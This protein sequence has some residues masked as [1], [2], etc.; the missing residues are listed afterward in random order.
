MHQALCHVDV[1][2]QI[3]LTYYKEGWEMMTSAFETNYMRGLHPLA[4]VCK[5]W[6][7]VA[8]HHF[9]AK[10]MS[11]EV[12]QPPDHGR[13]GEYFKSAFEQDACTTMGPFG[14]VCT[15]STRSIYHSNA[16]LIPR[17]GNKT[18]TFYLY[19]GNNVTAMDIVHCLNCIAFAEYEWPLVTALHIVTDTIFTIPPVLPPLTVLSICP[20]HFT[21]HFLLAKLSAE[22]LQKL[23][24]HHIQPRHFFKTIGISGPQSPAVFPELRSLGLY[25]SVPRISQDA[26]SNWYNSHEHNL[27]RFPKLRLVTI[28][29][30]YYNISG[31]FRALLQSPVENLRISTQPLLF[32][33]AEIHRFMSIKK[34]WANFEMGQDQQQQQQ[35]LAGNYFDRLFSS[36]TPLTD[37]SICL[38]SSDWRTSMTSI[39]SKLLYTLDL[40]LK[41]GYTQAMSIM[42]GLPRLVHFRCVIDTM[43]VD[44]NASMRDILCQSHPICSTTVEHMV[45][46][47]HPQTESVDISGRYAVLAHMLSLIARVPSLLHLRSSYSAAT[48][49]MHVRR[50]LAINEFATIGRHLKNI[51]YNAR[52]NSGSNVVFS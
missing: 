7:G 18:T 3:F 20:V 43:S 23:S 6:R 38:P 22:H 24:L 12:F 17:T 45:L 8:Y 36:Q 2:R 14:Y 5:T 40:D 48:F 37:M 42:S 31:I 9:L 47:F 32:V 46:V 39:E 16:Y 27:V 19:L 41:L 26:S 44:N 28:Y 11:I 21:H 33:S 50:A 34:L 15:P 29:N 25:F 51:K 1:L 10:C 4:A 35:L 52:A 49:R 13:R 30:Y